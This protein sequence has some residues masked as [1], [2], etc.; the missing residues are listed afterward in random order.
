MSELFCGISSV[1]H[2]SFT[3]IDDNSFEVKLFKIKLS[4][5]HSVIKD[6]I[7]YLSREELTHSKRYR[8]QKEINQYIICRCLLKFILSQHT[9]IPVHNINIA[10]DE[11]KKPYLVNN[12]LVSFNLSHS[13][14]YGVIAVGNKFSIGIDIEYINHD[15]DFSEIL[16]NVY[17]C[18]EIETIYSSKS[19][20]YTFFKYWTRKESIVK[21]TG[22]GISDYLKEIPATDGW[23][24]I[25]QKISHNLENLN[26][27]TFNL[28]ENYIV[29]LAVNDKNINLEKIPI[30]NLPSHNKQLL[31]FAL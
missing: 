26:V 29:S 27:C 4:S 25:S 24:N 22:L 16:K 6:L 13:N 23:H 30:Y 14:D 8:F 15:F 3:T 5:Y 19:S 12:R 17:S 2:E 9:K 7:K 18:H 10:I 20:I 28:T 11:H 21:A 1:S 31:A